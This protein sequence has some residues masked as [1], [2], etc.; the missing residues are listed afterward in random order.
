MSDTTGWHRDYAPCLCRR[1]ADEER[2]RVGREMWVRMEII[3]AILHEVQEDM[4]LV[5]GVR[6]L[7]DPACITP[8]P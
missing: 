2:K 3:A 4:H 1:R 6:P 5:G 8:G 7:E